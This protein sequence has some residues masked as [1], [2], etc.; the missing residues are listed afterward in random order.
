MRRRGVCCTPAHPFSDL[1][2]PTEPPYPPRAVRHVAERGV[3]LPSADTTRTCLSGDSNNTQRY[4]SFTTFAL[5]MPKRGL[6]FSSLGN[7]VNNM[8]INRTEDG[9]FAH[10]VTASTATYAMARTGA[11]RM[12]V[13]GAH[14]YLPTLPRPCPP[15]LAV[16][17]WAATIQTRASVLAGAGR[18]GAR[19]QWPS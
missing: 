11:R 5:W 6:P 3:C 12:R 8:N 16:C 15:P 4:F 14:H 9:L 10:V 2:P 19:C 13:A 18:G 17:P 1:A 7:S